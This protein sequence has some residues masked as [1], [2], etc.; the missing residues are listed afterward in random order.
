[1]LSSLVDHIAELLFGAN[2]L[3]ILEH[4]VND[5]DEDETKVKVLVLLV[6]LLYIFHLDS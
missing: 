1:M 2:A 4:A 5:L 3:D 6:N